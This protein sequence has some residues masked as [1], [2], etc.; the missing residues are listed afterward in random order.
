MRIIIRYILLLSI[1]FINSCTKNNDT[2]KTSKIRKENKVDSTIIKKTSGEQPEY[3]NKTFPVKEGLLSDIVGGSYA[4][5]HEADGDLN[6]DGLSDKVLVLRKKSDTFFQRTVLV[7][8]KNKNNH[9]RLDK[10]SDILLPDEYNEAGFKKYDPESISI[11]KGVLSVNLYNPAP[12]GNLF[13]NFKYIDKDFVLT[14]IETYNAGA[15][16]S[17]SLYYEPLKGKLLQEV[18]DT[19]EEDMPAETK[20]IQVK[21]QKFLFENSVPDDIISKVYSENDVL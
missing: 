21:K 9:F 16:S 19:M 11:A 6:N 8:L 13:F 4:I 7:L 5:Q 10:I 15:G 2:G 17:Q 20:K 3:K 18:T 1:I 14:Y 12:Y